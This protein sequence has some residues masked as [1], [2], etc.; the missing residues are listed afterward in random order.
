MTTPQ[1]TTKFP[2]DFDSILKKVDSNIEE[3]I[4]II[5]WIGFTT[6]DER[7]FIK[8]LDDLYHDMEISMGVYDE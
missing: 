2:T 3:I 5:K 4:E 7:H 6:A 1:S 8:V